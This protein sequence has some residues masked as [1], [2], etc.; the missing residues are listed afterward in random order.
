M[1]PIIIVEH[2]SKQYH[3]GARAGPGEGALLLEEEKRRRS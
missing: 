2:L 1:R 3:I